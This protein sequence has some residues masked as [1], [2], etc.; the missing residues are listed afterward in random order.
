[1]FIHQIH[2]ASEHAFVIA[3]EEESTNKVYYLGKYE[4]STN[5]VHHC[6]ALD[7]WDAH[8]IYSY[9]DKCILGGAY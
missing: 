2:L 6:Q 5:P 7:K 1:M 9:K 3:Y 4:D 8:R